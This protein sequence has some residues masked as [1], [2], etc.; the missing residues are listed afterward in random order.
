MA[1]PHCNIY[2]NSPTVLR[3]TD[4][5]PAFGP[6]IIK[7]R[8]EFLFPPFSV[9]FSLSKRMSSGTTCLSCFSSASCNNGWQACIQ[10]RWGTPFTSGSKA[11]V[12]LANSVFAYI[13]SICARK[14]YELRIS[15]MCGRSSSL[16]TVR[17]RTIS[18]RS[19]ASS[20][21]TLLLASTTSVGSM[22]TVFPVADSSC[23]I[24]LILRFTPGATGITSRPSRT[25]GVTSLS[26]NP[27]F[28]AACKIV[29]KV[30]DIE[31]SIF[32]RS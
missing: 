27:S 13:K 10:S 24:P 28:W 21:R 9:L 11:L 14:A 15:V 19:A 26:T 1:S 25:A 31:P 2:C 20:S 7:R 8:P 17:I 30:R 16:N 22:N 18:R 29:Y 3:H 4:F 6:L 23:T 32:D 5:P 12:S